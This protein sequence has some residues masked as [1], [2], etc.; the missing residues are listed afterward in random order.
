MISYYEGRGF[1][2]LSYMMKAHRVTEGT[3]MRWVRKAK[4]PPPSRVPSLGTIW[5]AEDIYNW[6]EKAR[7][8]GDPKRHPVAIAR[9]RYNAALEDFLLGPADVPKGQQASPKEIDRGGW[10]LVRTAWTWLFAKPPSA[11]KV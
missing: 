9:E 5:W 4:Y 8:G 2:P 7:T 10:Q 3:I 11:L 1:F 6:A